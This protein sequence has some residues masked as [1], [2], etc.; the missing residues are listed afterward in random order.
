M[1]VRMLRHYDS[2]GLLRPAKVD[3][4]SGYRY[5][6]VA[7]FNRLNRLVALKDLGF[8]LQDVAVMIDD[9]ADTA[10]LREML[11]SRRADLRSRI[12]AD[13]A[14]LASVQAR[15]RAIESETVMSDITV[16]TVPSIR[17][18]Q[19]SAVADSWEPA[20]IAPVVQPLC[21][22]LG[23]V[24]RAAGVTPTGELLV[25][26]APTDDERVQVFAAI[27]VA[28]DPN[29]NDDF[30]VV[31]LPAVTVASAVHHGS[32]DDVLPLYQE[33]DRW[34]SDNGHSSLSLGREVYRYYGAGD[35][36]SWV[37][38]IQVPLSA[39]VEAWPT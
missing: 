9:D 17:V 26:Y 36:S 14:A 6:D 5:Y 31:D 12:E 19:L 18:A 39:S 2:I 35:P 25:H 23:E 22:R 13:R 38:E 1:S 29:S 24:L 27:P 4:S 15:L 11:S 20:S 16:V 10:R 33:I 37:T 34:I 3:G 21:G 32:M 8:T 28:V 7:Q 30:D